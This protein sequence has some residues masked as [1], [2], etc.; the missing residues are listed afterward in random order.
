MLDNIEDFLYKEKSLKIK[1]IK[2]NPIDLIEKIFITNEKRKNISNKIT[3]SKITKDPMFK[4]TCKLEEEKNKQI[5]F[6]NT[7]ITLINEESYKLLLAIELT[8]AYSEEKFNSISKHTKHAKD[9]KDE[10]DSILSIEG[11]DDLSPIEANNDGVLVPNMGIMDKDKVEKLMLNRVFYFLEIKV[12]KEDAE[13]IKAH[14]FNKNIKNYLDVENKDRNMLLKEMSLN[15]K[16][17]DIM[18]NSPDSILDFIKEIEGLEENEQVE[19]F[20]LNYSN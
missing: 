17:R 19:I 10:L 2:K 5:K 8:E 9:L 16:I 12:S 15:N 4:L 20:H 3:F 18:I 7:N 6:L 1:E 14:S 13:K 11:L